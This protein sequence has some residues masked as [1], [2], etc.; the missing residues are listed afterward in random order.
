MP[1]AYKWRPIEDL[2]DDPKSLTDGELNSLKRVW[3]NQREEMIQIGTLD[4]FEQRLRRESSIATGIIEGVYA[5]DRGVTRTL[6]AKGIDAALIP[7]DAT[8]RDPEMVAR[9][10]QDHYKA[11]DGLFDF[12][13][14]QRRL[15]TGYVKELHAALL[16]NQPTC[17]VVDQFGQAFEKRLAPDTKQ[18]ALRA[19]GS[20]SRRLAVFPTLLPTQ[21]P[22]KSPGTLPISLNTAPLPA[23]R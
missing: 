16:R 4:E 19:V 23:Y 7:R 10:L 2:S 17:T 6:I 21:R 14:G 9:I 8:D 18:L 3:A 5:L 15:S 20:F 1:N 12:V 22:F 13:G 11:L